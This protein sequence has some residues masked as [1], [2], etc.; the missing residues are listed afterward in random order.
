MTDTNPT[1]YTKW[2]RLQNLAKL[3]GPDSSC[4]WAVKEIALLV[5]L[6]QGLEQLAHTTL[7]EDGSPFASAV[8]YDDLA[9]DGRREDALYQNEDDPQE[10]Y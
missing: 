4:Q 8:G 7:P 6:V 9:H 1:G 3:L 10:K 5:A 2:R